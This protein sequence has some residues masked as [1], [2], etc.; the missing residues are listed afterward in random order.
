MTH[1]QYF[2][3]NFAGSHY[4]GVRGPV[5][6][7]PVSRATRNCVAYLSDWCSFWRKTQSA[8]GHPMYF[9]HKFGFNDV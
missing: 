4:A 2:G 6:E 7:K 5:G 1:S 8:A 3:H 9:L